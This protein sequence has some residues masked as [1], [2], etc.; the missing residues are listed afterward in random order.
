MRAD[1]TNVVW[2]AEVPLTL[3]RAVGLA[4]AHGRALAR[5][6]LAVWQRELSIQLAR[7]A[8]EPTAG[9]VLQGSGFAGDRQW[10]YGIQL[11]IPT[12]WGTRLGA[13]AT[14]TDRDRGMSD[15]RTISLEIHQP[16][17]RRF[18]RDVHEEAIRAAADDF[19]AQRRQY[20][21][22]RADLVLRLAQ[23]LDMLARLDLL[24]SLETGRYQRLQQLARLV[25]ARE[26]QGRSSRV[27]S[28]RMEQ[29]VAEAA[30]RLEDL[31][32][33]RKTAW[34]E[35]CLWLGIHIPEN[36]RIEAPPWLADALP[37]PSTAVS[38]AFSNRLDIAQAEDEARA[39][40]RQS[41]IA[42]RSV[43]PDL[44]LHGTLRNTWLDG[45][46]GGDRD[47]TDWFVGL[48]ADGWPWRSSDRIRRQQSELSIASAEAA[49]ELQREVVARQVLDALGACQSARNAL[50]AAERSHALAEAQVRLARRLYETGRGDAFDLDDG[51]TRWMQSEHRVLEARSAVRISGYMLRHAMGTLVECPEDLKPGR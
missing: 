22:Q 3:D 17:F 12:M 51:E 25:R 5:G 36:V 48:T 27:D 19:R 15:E 33:R 14:A 4:L 35:L 26:R 2:P 28:I 34:R 23:L 18:G 32:E 49:V 44:T 38:I 1:E 13:E 40:A 45:S 6:Q 20:E 8:F 10:T 31:A 9:P 42:R 29:Q 39:A 7:A 47:R 50:A 21:Q 41:N 30:A 11:A 24:Q 16:L 43:W 37:D 46:G